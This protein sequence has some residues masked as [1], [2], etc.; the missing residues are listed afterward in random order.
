MPAVRIAGF[1]YHDVTDDRA[2][3]GFQRPGAWPYKHTWAAFRGHLDAISTL[4]A[5]PVLVPDLDFSRGGR[6]LVL[7]FDDGGSSAVRIG[8][9]LIHRGWRGHFF[10]VTGLIGQRTFVSASDVRYLRSCGHVVGSHS[11]T[12]P[13]IFRRLPPAQMLREWRASGEVLADL[14]GEPCAV[15]SVP[16]G[17][18]SRAVLE[19]AAEAGLSHLFT[20]EP[21]PE[22]RLVRGCWILGRCHVK[23]GTTPAQVRALA[24]LEG[25]RRARW[26][27]RLKGVARTLFPPLYAH[28]VRRMTREQPISG[29]QGDAG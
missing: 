10:I 3:S 12:H 8:D 23:A 15:A 13:D 25:W 26:Q 18:V 21:V 6:H 5:R 20:S 22:P 2:T 4:G 19:S 14:L 28:Y 7:T 16:G 27:R 1:G 17:D 11:H 29:H 24:S 9:E